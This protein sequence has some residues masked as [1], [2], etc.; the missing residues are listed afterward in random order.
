VISPGSG[1]DQLG[2][3]RDQSKIEVIL[4]RSADDRRSTSPDVHPPVSS[5]RIIIIAR[6]LQRLFIASSGVTWSRDAAWRVP[7]A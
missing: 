6:V 4:P 2:S 5:V 7:L 3:R 1:R